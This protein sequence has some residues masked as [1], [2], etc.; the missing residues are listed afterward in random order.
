M[1]KTFVRRLRVNGAACVK[2]CDGMKVVEFGVVYWKLVTFRRGVIYFVEGLFSYVI[3]A[4]LMYGLWL[5]VGI[6]T[7]VK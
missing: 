5:S 1:R 4:V 2:M 3:F 6:H 7:S